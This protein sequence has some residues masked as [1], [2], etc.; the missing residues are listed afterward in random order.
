LGLVK[1]HI[2]IKLKTHVIPTKI[3]TEMIGEHEVDQI[4]KRTK[5][6][7][8]ELRNKTTKMMIE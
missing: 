2:E 6:I 5:S 8:S 4:L 1:E 3:D 7:S